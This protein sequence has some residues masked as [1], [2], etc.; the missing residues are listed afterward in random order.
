MAQS[1]KQGF[2]SIFRTM[3]DALLHT[4][5]KKIPGVRWLSRFVFRAIWG[6]QHIMEIQGSKMIIDLDH[7]NPALQQTFQAYAMRQIHEETTTALFKKFIKPGDVVLDLGANIG[8]FSLLSARLTGPTGKVFS[9]EPEPNNFRYLT[10]NLKLNGYAHAHPFNIAA[11]NESGTISLFVCEYDSGHH[12]IKNEKGI[13]SYKEGGASKEIAIEAVKLDQF[14]KDKTD[15]VD[16]IKMDVE[17]AEALALEGMKELLKKNGDVTVIMEFFP[18][19]IS[20]MGSSPERMV[21]MILDE[22][23]FNMFIIGHD[24]SMEHSDKN[25]VQVKSYKELNSYIVGTMDHVNLILSRKKS[26]S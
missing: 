17:G 15:R 21:S 19:F 25:F 6:T 12:T 20:A 8:Y 5:I 3:Y 11:S 1:L 16:F 22:L 23:G 2:V 26:I 18:Y 24:Y 13:S 4:P 9:F 14:L 7:R 10:E